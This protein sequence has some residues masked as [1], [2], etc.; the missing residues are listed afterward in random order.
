M[1]RVYAIQCLPASCFWIK[2]MY[3]TDITTHLMQF[4]FN[5]RQTNL[6]PKSHSLIIQRVLQNK[7]N[8][9]ISFK[10]DEN[11]MRGDKVQ[12]GC[13]WIKRL[14]I[15]TSSM[16][17]NCRYTIKNHLKSFRG[18]DI[19]HHTHTIIF[20]FFCPVTGDGF[21]DDIGWISFSI[22]WSILFG[23]YKGLPS[24]CGYTNRFHVPVCFGFRFIINKISVK[25]WYMNSRFR[26]FLVSVN[27]WKI[28]WVMGVLVLYSKFKRT[29][30]VVGDTHR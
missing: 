25:L 21:S 5:M 22:N 14:H 24:I 20:L 13:G 23:S 4:K 8:D 12:R 16:Q 27:E 6:L 3:H 11:K 29:E 9:A 15:C 1:N 17:L 19:V 30:V 18:V 2:S 10:T 26:C 7:S 28:G